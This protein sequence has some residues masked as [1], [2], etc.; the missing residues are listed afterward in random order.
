[1]ED[2]LTPHRTR[3]AAFLVLLALLL[4]ACGDDDTTSAV[5]ESGQRPDPADTD[6]TE[7]DTRDGAF[8]VS[9]VADNGEVTIDARPERIVSL[10]GAATEMLFAIGAGDQVAAVD[11]YSYHPPEAP[12]TDLEAYHASVEAVA[13]HDPDLVV[14]AYDPGGLIEG[15]GLLGIP[16][17]HLN[18]PDGFGGIYAQIELLGVATG[19]LAGAVGVAAEMQR[20]IDQIVSALP[21]HVAGLTYFHELDD[22]YYTV[23]SSTFI[24]QVYALLGLENIADAVDA[25]GSA[26]GYPQ[27]SE[28]YIIEAD[29]DLIFLAD[30]ACCG[31]S[32][33]TVAARPGWDDLRA[34]TTGAVVE[35]DEDVASR[36]GPRLVDYLR[37]VAAAIS[38]LEPVG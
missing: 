20:E 38:E 21:D 11:S 19:N 22:M 35:V 15:L 17:L 13:E 18:A 26:G 36:W 37:D 27:L 1:L 23:T 32:A 9:V 12:V 5:P 7:A 2:A 3:A 30:A 24:G 29:P 14:V 34:V 6:G 10:S 28:E 31:Q 33:A 25:D 4:G 8:P 16:V